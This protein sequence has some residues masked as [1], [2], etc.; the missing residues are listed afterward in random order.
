MASGIQIPTPLPML[1]KRRTFKN[2]CSKNIKETF[3]KFYS[4]NMDNLEC[5]GKETDFDLNTG[6]F[7]SQSG[8]P[9]FRSRQKGKLKLVLNELWGFNKF[10]L[11]GLN[12]GAYTSDGWVCP[13]ILGARYPDPCLLTKRVN[14]FEIRTYWALEI[15]HTPPHTPNTS[16]NLSCWWWCGP[17]NQ[18][19][20][21][22][23]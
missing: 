10:V 8:S 21:S 6:R 20:E 14:R 15:S 12:T 5:F 3:T 16:P 11:N 18:C 7:A 19:C 2:L 23:P 9:L 22:R 13:T 4:E 17:S 1:V